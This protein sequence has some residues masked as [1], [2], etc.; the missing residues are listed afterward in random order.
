MVEN[1]EKIW[2]KV[3]DIKKNDFTSII[4][5]S[6]VLALGT[7]EAAIQ[8]KFTIPDDYS[9]IG[10]D[11]ILATKYISPPLTTVHQPKKRTGI[12]SITYL[13]E[14]IEGNSKDTKKMI[15]D[16]VLIERKSVKEIQ[17]YNTTRRDPVT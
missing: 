10:Y 17:Q 2:K 12:Y 15:I 1:D 11:N 8:L 5:L 3:S 14:Q 6:D 7:Y 16:P 4:T 9:I 13:L